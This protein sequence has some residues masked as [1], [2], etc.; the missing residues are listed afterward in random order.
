NKLVRLFPQLATYT[1][2]TTHN[3]GLINDYIFS[4]AEDLQGNLLIGTNGSGVQYFN[5]QDGFG[6][7]ISKAQGLPNEQIAFVLPD[8]DSTLWIATYWGLSNYNP[9]LDKSINY[10]TQSGFSHNEFNRFSYLKTQNSSDFYFGGMNGINKFNPQNLKDKNSISKLH[11]SEI[12]WQEKGKTKRIFQ[13]I[14]DTEQLTIYPP[15]HS[16]K[17]KFYNKDFTH[18]KGNNYNYRVNGLENPEQVVNIPGEIFFQNLP[19]GSYTVNITGTN[20]LAKESE[21][22]LVLNLKV[23]PF[24]FE[25]WYFIAALTILFIAPFL[26]YWRFKLIQK[27]K[28]ER[29]RNSIAQNLHDELGS[30]VAQSYFLISQLI[31]KGH[32]KNIEEERKITK[33]MLLMKKI[34]SDI[35]DLSWSIDEEFNSIGHMIERMEDYAADLLTNEELS[36]KVEWDQRFNDISTTYETRQNILLIFKEAINNIRQHS[37]AQQ[38]MINLK[39]VDRNLHLNIYNDL[40]LDLKKNNSSGMGIKNMKARA[41]KIKGKLEASTSSEGFAI[42][43]ICPI[44]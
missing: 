16:L 33:A 34:A 26:I 23:K 1:S 32:K 29:T 41:Q 12:S 11:W 43:L 42:Q 20:A 40:G 28:V 18:P 9:S 17:L 2:Y 21:N 35:R 22:E 7:V 27:I 8:Q 37:K 13:P 14:K 39:I 4:L 25:T 44:L 30:E 24:F 31:K 6:K 19:K 36:F 15:S 3:S 5:D 10:F 38:V